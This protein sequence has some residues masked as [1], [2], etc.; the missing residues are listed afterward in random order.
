MKKFLEMVDRIPTEVW[1]VLIAF[2]L[3]A[4]VIS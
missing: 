3:L 1:V 2:L 4:M